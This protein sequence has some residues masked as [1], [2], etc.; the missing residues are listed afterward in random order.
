M[1]FSDWKFNRIFVF[2]LIAKIIFCRVEI[3]FNESETQIRT[4][5][6]FALLKMLRLQTMVWMGASG[7]NGTVVSY[8][9]GKQIKYE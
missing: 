2:G 5:I 9:E 7:R 8:K 1:A 3:V 4:L 6:E